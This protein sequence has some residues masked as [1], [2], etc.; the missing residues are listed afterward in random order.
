METLYQN[1][2]FFVIIKTIVESDKM[3]K[4]FPTRAKQH[5]SDDKGVAIFTYIISDYFV[6]RNIEHNDYGI[7]C[8]IDLVESDR[9][10]DSDVLKGKC[11]CAQ[12]KSSD[13][14][15]NSL[16]IRRETFMYWYKHQLPVFLVHVNWRTQLFKFANVREQLR[17]NYLLL[18]DKTVR[19]FKFVLK[20]ST[21][22]DYDFINEK[23]CAGLI[24]SQKELSQIL[25]A[26]VQHEL[27][28]GIYEENLGVLFSNL[29]EKFEDWS[30]MMNRDFHLE[31]DYSEPDMKLFLDAYKALFFVSIYNG[32]SAYTELKTPDYFFHKRLKSYPGKMDYLAEIDRTD[33]YFSLFKDYFVVFK[34]LKES[35]TKEN[36]YWKSK[37]NEV[38]EVFQ[39]STL[40]EFLNPEFYEWQKKFIDSCD[41]FTLPP[42]RKK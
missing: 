28:R 33:A 7:D 19:D 32:I 18:N 5:I 40:I 30:L 10:F 21:A 16:V 35:I 1:K 24:K 31:I 23:E 4:E 34:A 27:L 22:L 9:D 17:Q 36:D 2:V 42:S 20:N 3:K 12:L 13:T 38:F 6:S 25:Y 29:K 26:E 15:S 14:N 41:A 8:L 11:F 39:A 37:N